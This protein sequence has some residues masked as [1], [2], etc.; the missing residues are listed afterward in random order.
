MLNIKNSFNNN[1]NSPMTINLPQY[2][3]PKKLTPKLG[4]VNTSNFVGRVAELEKVDK[5]LNE[6]DTLLLI[7][8]IG[9]IGK[10]TLASYYFNDKKDSFD[11]YGYIQVDDNIQLAC[12]TA[13]KTSL[14]L[15]QEKT[16]DLFN[17]AMNKLQN[18]EG[19]KL[20]IIDDVKDVLGQE[21]EI[22]KLL[23]LKNSGFKILFTSREVQE[24]IP[25]YFLDIMSP[26]DARELFL[27][28]HSS[29]EIDKV[30]KIL[31]YL[32]YHTLFI[33][34]TAIALTKRKRTL[35]LDNI[36][37]KFTNGEFA[38]I[39][40][41]RNESFNKFLNDLFADDKILKDEESLLFIKRLSVLPSIE[42]SFEDLYR[43]LV[44]E[45][46]ARLELFL[47][48]IVANGWLIEVNDT[49]KFH[50]ILRE[51]IFNNYLP[52]FEEIEGILDYYLEYQKNVEDIMVTI[53]NRDNIIFFDVIF[54]SLNKINRGNEK[55]G[56]FFNNLG[57]IY[58]HLGNYKKSKN[59]YLK[60][61][62]IAEEIWGV[63]NPA[64][65][66]SYSN[67]GLVYQLM[68]DDEKAIIFQFKALHILENTLGKINLNVATSYLN[69]AL[70]YYNIGKYEEANNLNFYALNITQQILGENNMNVASA[71][72]NIGEVYKAL[73]EY[74]EAESY[75]LKAININKKV[76]GENHPNTATSYTNL[77]RIYTLNKSYGEAEKLYFKALT[78]R[79]ELWKE[80]HQDII[81]SYNNMGEFYRIVEDYK[82]SKEFYLKALELSENISDEV[83]HTMGTINNN[84]AVLS[85]DNKEFDV[86]YEYM[87]KAILI[88][89]K[90]LYIG[91]PHLEDSINGLKRIEAKLIS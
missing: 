72:N 9:G 36:I 27:K 60:A 48:E 89:E 53:N 42:I 13:F 21:K 69:L 86:S 91:H 8:G 63:N 43:F 78:I 41:S 19:E 10:S 44:C 67:L 2:K 64:T 82:K 45:D 88:R 55:I 84:L 26:E 35:T 17:E 34:M 3:I 29:D 75:I 7:N 52:K 38:T 62:E 4:I 24:D 11:H 46:E 22:E 81:I 65:G 39:E 33:K 74:T 25:Q 58:Y 59:L 32:D 77:A 71:Y 49:Y 61:L 30:D 87:K 54:D 23:S 66:S 70:L 47:N 6:S 1:T 15:K 5:L 79:E 90:V 83:S 12:T 28:Y 16:E 31:E 18:L 85:Y 76:V 50:Q 56:I 20:L 14:D 51:F 57:L 73:K 68:G 37:E 80:G 40:K